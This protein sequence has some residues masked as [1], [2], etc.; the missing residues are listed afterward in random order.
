MVTRLNPYNLS[1]TSGPV[2]FKTVTEHDKAH[3]AE[4]SGKA[5]VEDYYL[6]NLGMGKSCNQSTSV[7]G[8]SSKP[9]MELSVLPEALTTVLSLVHYPDQVPEPFPSY[10]T[11]VSRVSKSGKG[12]ASRN[13][14]VVDVSDAVKAGPPMG[15]VSHAEVS[16]G[17]R[18]SSATTS[19]T[20]PMLKVV[21]P[22][23]DSYPWVAH[24][25]FSPLSDLG[26]GVEDEFEEGEV[27][28]E[29]QRGNSVVSSE[30]AQSD[31]GLHILQWETSEVVD[32]SCDNGERFLCVG[33]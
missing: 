28:E 17:L 33:V 18:V 26:N 3:L 1:N 9:P 4:P 23:L 7:A 21:S 8:E 30:G 10:P 5:Q 32:H 12:S 6:L 29:V 24:N 22:I 14:S 20:T 15:S 16:L 13:G 25:R 27:Q 19:L 2:L 31:S 11:R